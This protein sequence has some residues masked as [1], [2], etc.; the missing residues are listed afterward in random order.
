[1][2]ALIG[3]SVGLLGAC[4]KIC[5]EKITESKFEQVE[6]FMREG[7]FGLMWFCVVLISM[8]LA[9]TSA[10]IIIKF[11]PAA[12][13]SGIPDVMAYLNGVSIRRVSVL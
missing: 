12:A 11:E 8:A 4:L 10:I 3:F 2:M 7:R 9:F 13:G 5:I 1:M 6:H